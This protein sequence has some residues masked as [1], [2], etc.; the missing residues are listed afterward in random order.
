M[1]LVRFDPFQEMT[2]AQNRINHV[3]A[4]AFAGAGPDAFGFLPAVDIRIGTDHTLIMEADLP[5]VSKD[6]VTVHI[7][8]RTLTIKGVAKEIEVP[9]EM[10]AAGVGGV[11]VTGK[12]KLKMTDW[13]V[14][15]PKL[16]LG[17]LKVNEMVT[18]GFDL[19]LTQ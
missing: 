5:G 6:A 3:L 4:D 11:R 16:M 17:T 18:I 2:T 19:L 7:E 13:G 1:T 14:K 12:Y 8:N 10:V 9:V 15:P